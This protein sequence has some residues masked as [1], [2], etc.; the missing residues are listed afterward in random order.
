MSG[1]WHGLCQKFT[2]RQLADTLRQVAP[3]FRPRRRS[4]DEQIK[5]K[6]PFAQAS[7]IGVIELPDNQT[8][9]IGAVRIKDILTTRSGKR[10]QY[11][12]AKRILKSGHFNGGIFAFYDD[13]RRFRFSLITVTYHGTRREFSSH[14]RHTFFIDPHLP[15]KT[16]LQQMQKTNFATRS[17]ILKAFSLEAV[18]N[19]FYREFKPRFDALAEAVRD[20]DDTELKHDFAL[21]FVIRIIFL[22]FVQKKGWLGRTNFLISCWKEYRLTGNNNTFYTDW[23][24]PLFFQALSSPPDFKTFLGGTPF[25]TETR[26]IFRRAPFLNG[27]LFKSKIGVDD[28]LLY[29]PDK[30]I[31]EFFDFLF[32][33]NFTVE[34]NRLYDEELELNPEFLG[35]IFER[36]TTGE[37]GTVYTPREEVD[38]MC[39]LALVKWLGQ[40]TDITEKK[41]YRLFFHKIRPGK[42]KE[43]LESDELSPIEIQ[44][45]IKQLKGVTICDPTAGSGA[46]EVGMLQVLEQVIKKL[47]SHKN[48]P[49]DLKSNRPDALE[50]K[51]TILANS[52]Y[53][54]EVKR[55]AVWINQL[56]LWL[57]LFI[58]LPGD[59]PS[60]RG[61]PLLP[62]LT[63]KVRIGDSLVQHAGGEP[64]PVGNATDLPAE[65]KNRAR[66]LGRKKRD[67]FY[68]RDVD[69]QLI[70][71]EELTILSAVLETIIKNPREKGNDSEPVATFKPLKNESPFYWSA[72]FAEIMLTRGGFDIIISNP[73]YVRHEEITDPNGLLNP[74]EYKD[75][76]LEMARLDFRDYFVLS[77]T[78]PDRYWPDRKPSGRSDLYT[79]FYI[80][81]LRL[82][83][84]QGIHLF[85]CSNSWLDVDYGAWL[86][87]FFL[88]RAPLDLVIDNHA[89]RSFIRS[90]INTVITVAKAPGNVKKEKIIRFVAFKQPFADVI[91]YDNL[92]AIEEA[93]GFFHN[94]HFRVFPITSRKLLLEGLTTDKHYPA[95]QRRYIANKW[96]GKY[97]RAPDIFF[98]IMEKGRGKLVRLGEIAEVR[99]GITTGANDF[100]YLEPLGADS[101]P[102]LVRVCNGAGWEGEIEKEFLRPVLKS[103]RECRHIVIK[104]EDLKYRLFMC[105]QNKKGL[106]GTKALEYIK[107]GE[108]QGYHLRTTCQARTPWWVLEQQERPTAVWFKAFNDTFLTPVISSIGTYISDRFYALYP[109]CKGN[110]T[111]AL[112]N[113]LVALSTEIHGRVSLGEGVLDNM[114][115]E[116]TINYIINPTVFSSIQLKDRRVYNIFTECGIDPKSKIPIEKQE[117]K[118]LPDRKTLDNIVFDA[119]ELTWEERKEV[120]R[121]VCQLVWERLNKAGL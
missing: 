45:M 72:G 89:R 106:K 10:A 35:I 81:S 103:P 64:I 67:F 22:A 37:Q 7:Q 104:P 86:Q 42:S 63:F 54:V 1:I 34:E 61:H 78:H 94:Q 51:K 96:G 117:P 79:Y 59:T 55:W 44:I 107:W 57:T 4:L 31:G 40:T 105:Q 50:L 108:G 119:L 9:L 73:P 91:F 56:R 65:I 33:Y 92:L 15:N 3:S 20:S 5:E 41:L 8:I 26:E 70:W 38:L 116:T 68:N 113:S 28:Q 110:W 101:G 17:E 23:L 90:E 14:R 71:K 95:S 52:I 39:R 6:E 58:D 118:P 102:G 76:L 121:A 88:Q 75:A 46:F 80:R 69:H 53:G 32:Q 84:P 83:N 11:S 120:Y 16:F 66:M 43:F 30:P 36:L 13:D 77:R 49:Q 21:L 82:L 18:S 62:N 24:K 97:L 114:V 19:E 48:T 60:L 99:R 112:N 87:Q 47:Y 98:S 2:P 93:T 109:K 115:Y 100:F 25:S 27:E 85:I 74:R 29:I 12:L 111:I